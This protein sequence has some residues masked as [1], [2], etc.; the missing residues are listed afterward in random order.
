MELR[1]IESIWKTK[2]FIISDASQGIGS[3][4]G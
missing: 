1:D 4:C 3:R 2:I